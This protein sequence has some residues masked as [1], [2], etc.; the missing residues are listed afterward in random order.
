M[1]PIPER[2]STPAAPPRRRA[3]LGLLS[4]ALAAAIWLPCLHFFFRS[5]AAGHLAPAGLSPKAER[6]L[7]R[8]NA[9]WLDP[10]LRERE[11]GRMRLSNAEWDF[12]ARSFLAWSLANV[13]L[14]DP[15]R[16]K[17]C[18]AVMD[19][20][21]DETMR[22]EREKGWRFFL[23]PYAND[24]PYVAQPEGSLFVDSEIAL[25]LGLRRL[26]EEREDYRAPLAGRVRLMVE[27][28][29]KSEFLV[30]E[31]YPDECWM[32]DHLIA[33]AAVR[34]AD[35][36]DGTDHS[37][38]LARWLSNAK[39]RFVDPKTGLLL[40][41]FTLSGRPIDGP[42]GSTIW[43]AAHALQILDPAFAED[44]Y[45]RAKKELSRSALGFG[46]AVEWPS[47]WTGPMDVDSGPIVPVL[48]VS[49]GSSGLAF[50]GASAFGDREFLSSLSATLDFA[51][52][53]EDSGGG[54]RYGASNAVGDAV[55]LY[56]TVLG[57]A[58]ARVRDAG[59]RR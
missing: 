55:L 38:F 46:Y 48:G 26:L 17:D 18:L 14:R 15:A 58:W 49:A 31:S 28:M 12:M 1:S 4:L 19:R 59:A 44:Q 30:A 3:L 25:M 47:S 29:E 5:D 7:A 21:L 23:M 27:R 41:S 42:E 56:S 13:G 36:L 45:R 57:P 8:Q 35:A 24:R 53:P 32:F 52:F 16:K 6:L 20:I 43:M 40:S 9:I 2:S 33:L 34:V 54:L 22:L 10:A 11:I 39:R 51:A 37:A 50:V